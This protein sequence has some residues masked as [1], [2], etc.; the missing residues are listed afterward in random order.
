MLIGCESRGLELMEK[1]ERKRLLRL[2]DGLT[3]YALSHSF[4]SPDKERL[5]DLNKIREII[6]NG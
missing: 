4:I 5:E 1:S 2:Y 3:M 6:Q